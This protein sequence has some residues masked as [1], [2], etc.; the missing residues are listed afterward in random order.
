MKNTAISAQTYA[1]LLKFLKREHESL[2]AGYIVIRGK[3]KRYSQ[4]IDGRDYGITQKTDKIQ[5]LVRKRYVDVLIKEITK[6]LNTPLKDIHLHKFP[7]HEEIIR[8]FPPT[9]QALPD[10][11]FKLSSL[12]AWIAEPFIK[13]S[14]HKDGLIFPTKSGFYVRSKEEVILANTLFDNNIPFKYEAPFQ[15][16]NITVHP[17]FTLIN[18]YT[19]KR[20]IW[21]HIGAFHIE[22]YGEKAH[23]K[24]LAYTQSG[25]LLNETL[26][27]TYA[28]DITTEGR[29]QA[30]IE[31]I[32]LKI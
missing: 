27:I 29:I 18:P 3:G 23:R 16:G 4:R 6:Y 28:S 2:P 19:G 22:K 1:N 31:N 21:E 13:R 25:L 20:F 24:I 10:S 32:I 15:L 8:S 5:Q 12:G 14:D 9:V 11:Y 26:I 17:D 7:T 30:L